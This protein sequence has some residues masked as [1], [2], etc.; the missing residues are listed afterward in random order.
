MSLTGIARSK[1]LKLAVDNR[2]M[3]NLTT[4]ASHTLTAI[5]L[6]TN[7]LVLHFRHCFA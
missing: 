6:V 4:Q 2:G 5:N 7:F 1:I 3:S